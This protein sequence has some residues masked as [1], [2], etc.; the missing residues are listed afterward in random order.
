MKRLIAL[1]ATLILGS[2]L[3]AQARA[4]AIQLTDPSQLSP[5]DT[6]ATYTG[7]DGDSEPSPYSV[8]AGGNTLTFTTSTTTDFE[9]VD[10]GGPNWTLSPFPTGT[11]LL[12]DLDSSLPNGVVGGPVTISFGTGVHEAGLQIQ[13]DNYT[14][15][16]TFTEDVY[17]GNALIGSFTVTDP[18]TSPSGNLAFIGAQAT[19]SDVITSIVISSVDSVDP[20]TYNNDFAMGP[21]TFGAA[22]SSVPEP[23]S[24]ALASVSTLGLMLY[25]WRRRPRA[26]S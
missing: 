1:L 23:S 5:S 3:I 4:G 14:G 20:T 2:S 16:T 6:T 10:A 21:V 11:K 12:W 7:S 26:S 13:P 24:L 18:Q 17:N 9:R 15:T 19:G 22:I 25:G 8:S